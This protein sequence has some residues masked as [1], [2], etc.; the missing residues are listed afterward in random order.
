VTYYNIYDN[1]REKKL[2]HKQG[3]APKIL[4]YLH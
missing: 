2:Q 3:V 4:H 1:K